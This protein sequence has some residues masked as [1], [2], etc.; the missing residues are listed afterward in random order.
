MSTRYFFDTEF[1]ED[2]HTI[3]LISIGIVCEDG[4]EFYAVNKD[5]SRVR[6]FSD[7]WL[8]ENVVPHLPVK[9]ILDNEPWSYSNMDEDYSHPA[10][11]P[12][13]EIAR[14]ICKFTLPPTLDPQDP[15]PQQYMDEWSRPE[16]WAYYA[17]YDWVALCQLFG[18]MIDLPS[19]WP[20]YCRDLK[21]LADQLGVKFTKQIFGEHH[22]L[23]D[24]RWVKE[25]FADV[26][27]LLPRNERW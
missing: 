15:L 21:Q 3:E 8:L 14:A 1:L 11:M 10:W 12:R 23:S 16:W 18:R 27:A 20:M 6:V 25:H 17:D 7:P 24:A 4:R 2:G 5:F 19:G 9:K 13:R 22:A 26:E